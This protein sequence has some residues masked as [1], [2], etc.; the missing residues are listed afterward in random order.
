MY[1]GYAVYRVPYTPTDVVLMLMLIL[2]LTSCFT[3][4]RPLPAHASATLMQP[5]HIRRR[6]APFENVHRPRLPRL[7]V[8]PSRHDSTRDVL[9]HG[10]DALAGLG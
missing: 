8:L 3:A 4:P 7:L 1:V 10:G 9:E 2:T 5:Y 6:P